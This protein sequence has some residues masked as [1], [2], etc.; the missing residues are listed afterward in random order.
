MDHPTFHGGPLPFITVSPTTG[1]FIVEE[2]AAKIVSQIKGRVAV[3]AVAGLYRSGKSFLMNRLI[4]MQ[5]GFE[6]G[7]SVNPCTKGIWIWGQPVQLG[8]DY[9]AI[10]M[11]SEGLGS[12]SHHH[13]KSVDAAILTLSV[14]ASSY[15]IFNSMGAISET[16]LDQFAVIS[17]VV[18]AVS[19][20]SS[21]SSFTAPTFLWVLRDF[22]L[23]LVNE[24]D[25]PVSAR[26]YLESALREISTPEKNS[27]RE[28]IKQL[29][30]ERDCITMPRPLENEAELRQ[31]NKVPFE[32][33]RTV[34]RHQIENFV[35][36]VY[37]SIEPKRVG[38]VFLTGQTFCQLIGQYCAI[39]NANSGSVV[40]G[41]NSCAWEM[42]VQNTLKA[43]LRDAVGMYRSIL[44]EDGMKKLPL[45][46]TQLRALHLKAK[47][48]SKALF[49]ASLMASM[50]NEDPELSLLGNGGDPNASVEVSSPGMFLREF[51]ARREQ[52][53]D[54]LKAENHKISLSEIEN[55]YAQL[56]RQ[57]IDPAETGS[58]FKMESWRTVVSALEQQ[59]VHKYPASVVASFFSKQLIPNMISMSSAQVGG[60]ES[61]KKR[62]TERV[63]QLESQLAESRAIIESLGRKSRQDLQGNREAENLREMVRQLQD[64]LAFAEQQNVLGS[65]RR[66]LGGESSGNSLSVEIA[67]IKDLLV[68]SL[69]DMRSMESDKRSVEVRAENERT[70]IE[71]ERRFTK[72]LNEARR[73]N[74]MMIDDLR[75]NYETEISNLKQQ[76]SELQD[77]VRDLEKHLAVKSAE[78]AKLSIALDANE[79]DKVLRSNFA[80]VINQQSELILQFLKNGAQ[81]TPHQFSELNKLK[82]QGPSK[83]SQGA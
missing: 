39:L 48:L 31:I 13:S 37:T 70:M 82:S 71:L 17:S 56:V 41:L 52:L 68:R 32:A 40:S 47:A 51:R 77:M 63:I 29:F 73:K 79:N 3:I 67:G 59:C 10:L 58:S 66:N 57:L 6:V 61:E 43:S 62:W 64:R 15:F 30:P 44:N 81:L 69:T 75:N 60:G 11:D 7:P 22:N 4:G 54:H 20:S 46:D 83:H 65:S 14:L 72:Q 50:N 9:Y 12:G 1:E 5:D 16:A 28:S 2:Y 74:E 26:D 27:I 53:M 21:S 42:V 35:E 38:S 8:E 25:Q 19:S 34:F 36:K 18:D 78:T 76:K 55:F 45:N 24:T 49:P 80:N 23:R 33:L